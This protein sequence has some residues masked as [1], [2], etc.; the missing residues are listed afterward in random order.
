MLRR[1]NA[2]DILFQYVIN[3]AD[4][5]EEVR[6]LAATIVQETEIQQN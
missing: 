4:A 6:R 3:R 5:L 2:K 1:E